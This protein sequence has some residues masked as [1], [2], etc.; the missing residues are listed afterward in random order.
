M[1]SDDA[2]PLA[3]VKPGP[4]LTN[5]LR[6]LKALH[7]HCLWCCDG[8]G[9]E[10]RLCP[11]KSCPHW[12]YRLGRKPTA[13]MVAEAGN[14][15]MH[16]LEDGMTVAEFYADGGTVLRAIR[17][18]CLD[19]S[20]GCKSEVRDCTHTTCDLYPFRFGTNPNRKMGEE[21]RELAAARLKVNIEKGTRNRG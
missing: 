7:Q 14:H 2:N 5:T 9:I 3:N 19:C 1:V 16:P 13:A 8:S 15:Q 17:R 4:E 20:G 10:V 12:G 18:R 6:P 11:A 21:Q